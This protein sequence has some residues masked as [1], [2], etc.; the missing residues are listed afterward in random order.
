MSTDATRVDMFLKSFKI[1]VPVERTW[2]VLL[3]VHRLQTN[4]FQHLLRVEMVV[5]VSQPAVQVLVH[6]AAAVVLVEVFNK[7]QFVFK[8]YLIL[9]MSI[10]TFERQG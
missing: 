8:L 7:R 3:V 2:I 6:L 9:Y 4:Y 1:L 10:Y 5:Q